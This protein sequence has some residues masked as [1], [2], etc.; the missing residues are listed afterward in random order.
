MSKALDKSINNPTVD[1]RLSVEKRFCRIIKLKHI[2]LSDVYENRIDYEKV[3]Y[4][5]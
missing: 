5:H 3:C 1:S 4:M 2:Q